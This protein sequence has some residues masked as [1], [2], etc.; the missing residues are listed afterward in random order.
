MQ[1]ILSIIAILLGTGFVLFTLI[2]GR[3]Q[4]IRGWSLALAM[5]VAVAIE[6]CDL[7]AMLRV[8][9]LLFWKKG[10]LIAE[11][12][13]PSFWLLF[14][15]TFAREGRL[16]DSSPAPL[17][18]LAAS[19]AFLLAVLFIPL[20]QF[21]YSP[22]FGDE[23]LLFLGRPGYYFSI[24]VLL[25]LTYILVQLERTLAAT[26]PHARW[27]GKFELIGAGTLLV[28]CLVYYSQGLLHR[29]IDMSLLPARSLALSAAV[30]LMAWSRLRRGEAMPIRISREMAFRS[31][32]VLAVGLYLI[33]L[34]LMGEGMRYFGETRRALVLIAGLTAG[35]GVAVILLSESVKRKIRVF[36]HKH[37]YREKYDYRDQWLRLTRQLSAAGSQDELFRGILTFYTETFAMQGSALFLRDPD[38]D[39][40]RPAAAYGL[41]GVEATFSADN[42]LLQSFG[43]EGWIFSAADDDPVVQE[44]HGYFLRQHGVSFAIP[45]QFEKT[46][47][48]FIVL[49]RPIN[50][51]ERYTYEDFDL[52]KMLAR[53]ATS[54]ILSMR[55]AEQLSQ[56]RELVAIG[57]VSAFVLH[58]LKNLVS[59][60]AMVGDNARHYLDDP[61]FQK[62]MLDV[63]GSTVAK[64]KALITRLKNL[65]EKAELQVRVCDLRELVRDGARSAGNG[66]VTVQGESVAAHID[67]VEIQ[68][69]V[70]NLVLNALEAGEG[71]PVQ[72]DTGQDGRA[73]FRVRDQGCGMSEEFIRTRLFKPFQ[74]TKDKGFGIGLYQ[75]KSIVEAHGGTI[76]VTS[77]EGGGTEFTVFLPTAGQALFTTELTEDTEKGKIQSL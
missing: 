55:L 46:L 50:R 21:I 7:M 11:S 25:Y 27:R 19:P 54:T 72:V 66:Q 57:K 9:D 65:E 51:Q 42:A 30:V 71:K 70:L 32:V 8:E 1:P 52:M 76:E 68:K 35:V 43:E 74:T 18:L 22:D 67:P 15:L 45:L 59:S 3:G 38:G 77:R 36:L 48:G 20:D 14:A 49:G 60:L 58:D 2:K 69:V 31:V 10:T 73:F 41:E 40:F 75:C 61:E 34:G 5:A 39:I 33:G 6:V 12:L 63:L 47:A 64:M 44:E 17:L 53:Q 24:G 37:F 28:A 56:A 26:P 23:K 29:T 62:D 4:G 13:L 16:R